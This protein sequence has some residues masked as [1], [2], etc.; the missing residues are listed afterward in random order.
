[1]NCGRCG[2]ENAEDASFCQRCGRRLTGLCP[3]C[4]QEND[5][6]AD[7]C[8]KC[9]WPLG[10]ES[11]RA[12]V[13]GYASFSLSREGMGADA[14]LGALLRSAPQPLIERMRAEARKSEGARKP[15]T[16]QF[17]DIV[18]STSMAE[19]LDPEE[20]REIVGGAHRIVSQAVHSYEGT[21]AQLLGDGVLAFFGAP[22]THEDD[23]LRA[24]LA[25]LE[26][27]AEISE[28]ARELRG[29][30][31]DFQM[32]IGIHTGTVVVGAV[33][34]D[35]HMEY[36]AIGDSVNLA[37]RLQD[38]AEPGTIFI[39]Q[40]TARLLGPGMELRD[41]GEL[42]LKGFEQPVRAFQV[43][44][45]NIPTRS[46]TRPRG[47]RAPMVG[48]EAE[49][50]ALEK[51][52]QQVV[53]GS[54]RI[55]FI[56]GEAGIGKSR[57]LEE[58]RR[59]HADEMRWL[60][61]HALSF[62]QGLS[63]WSIRRMIE[64]DIGFSQGEPALRLKVGLQKRLRKLFGEHSGGRYP[65]LAHLLGVDLDGADR[66]PIE[67]IDGETLK[68]QVLDSIGEY[69]SRLASRRPTALVFEDLHW[70]DA[71]SLSAVQRLFAQTERAPLLVLCVMRPTRNH[72]S[73]A[74]KLQAETDFGHRYVQLELGA[75]SGPESARLIHRLLS[76]SNLPEEARRA[77]L[78]PTE[79]NPLY[80]EEVI[81]DLIEKGIFVPSG[82]GFALGEEIRGVEIPD[83]LQGV[84][85]ARVDRLPEDV[86]RTL[87]LAAVIDRRFSYRLLREI[88]ETE[89]EDALRNHLIQL[90]RAD[91]IQERPGGAELE[92]VFK[93]ALIHQ[94]VYETLL[95]AQRREHHSRVAEA[96][97]RL[98]SD[99][100]EE[101]WGFLAH[102]LEL[103]GR[104]E[105]ALEYMLKLGDNARLEDAYEEAV[106]Q[107]IRAIDTCERIG[108]QRTAAH[109][110]MKLALV[111]Q[112]D[113]DFDR[114]YEANE[115][116]FA[117]R[118]GLRIDGVAERE[119]HPE[120]ERGE[121]FSM[122]DINWG[123]LSLDPA[124]SDTSN[125]N[126]ALSQIFAGVARLDADMN[127]VP[128][129]ARSWRVLDGG[130]RYVI[131]LRDDVTWSDGEPVTAGDYEFAWKRNLRVRENAFPA[132]LLDPVLGAR[133]YRLGRSAGEDS[134]GVRAL[135][136]ATLE[137]QL[138]SP[139]AYFPY[140]LALPI[141][142]PQPKHVAERYGDSW[143][144]PGKM[145]SNGAFLVEEFVP[146]EYALLRRSLGYFDSVLG[147]VEQARLRVAEDP[148]AYTDQFL[149]GGIDYLN[150]LGE[151][152]AK[153]L[154]AYRMDRRDSLAAYYAIL[155]PSFPLDD[156]RVRRAMAHALDTEEIAK[157]Y[158]ARAAL[159][160][161]I[162]P[163][164][165]GHSPD[166][167]LG[168][169]PDKARKLMAEAGYPGGR[170]FP[171]IHGTIVVLSPAPL[172]TQWRQVLGIEVEMEPLDWGADEA[173]GLIHFMGWQAD[174]P[175]PHNF[176][177]HSHFHERLK[178]HGWHDP[179]FDHL[180]EQGARLQDRQERMRLYRQAD[181]R[182][183]SES[184]IIV[185]VVY[186]P[187]EREIFV[188]PWVQGIDISPNGQWG[189]EHV[190]IDRGLE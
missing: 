76:D 55:V 74:L 83:T 111:Y 69:F 109:T 167:S 189:L 172:E 92:Y 146:G 184:A 174:F 84:L 73:W 87:Q 88:A 70:A 91:L 143:A 60:E 145:V 28:Y 38:A 168:F 147:N 170:G 131:R 66:T 185:P 158:R 62:G 50:A 15:V 148:G 176:L 11:K 171:R 42:V 81:Q 177:S 3:N 49:L 17:S 75:L 155:I 188:Q 181:R 36:L 10:L 77:I 120:S 98:H 53:S 33:G 161:I 132:N 154:D 9:G 82:A 102:H 86:R 116:A 108:D 164:M 99:R 2:Y 119:P 21:I 178:P 8:K 151:E 125:E 58:A 40:A 186:G 13:E 115:R 166:L 169:D 12:G 37:Q 118:S 71:S 80:L 19:R 135:D 18:S 41:R 153:E 187:N 104:P 78:A 112:N 142:F 113:F 34:D 95:L 7:F 31:D 136:S 157:Q 85:L 163:G 183:V 182:L 93:H 175:D 52:V 89:D 114:A 39:S 6:D 72:G 24:A 4:G 30:V 27:Q 67:S 57:L 133:D 103:A 144:E 123:L 124:K 54:G 20:W 129:A 162:P 96:L 29:M 159:G 5:T 121:D 149:A 130:A 173:T 141:T 90:Q 25:S 61:A 1:M 48:R 138:E 137:V 65:Y 63:Y 160:G 14:R 100:N 26:L 122:V 16:I 110:W 134:V 56:M 79:G 140:L 107:Y 117:L 46:R 101:I 152:T 44:L 32:R 64:A 156:P 35:L 106:Y 59:R 47:L 105:Q 43:M 190:I 45:G 128:H 179:V 180:L 97:E 126:F 68:H 150:T 23:P 127:V 139:V 51:S 22:I 165:P 94:V